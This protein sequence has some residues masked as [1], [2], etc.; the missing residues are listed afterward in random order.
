MLM[1]KPPQITMVWRAAAMEDSKACWVG[2]AS[3]M[4]PSVHGLIISFND[5]SQHTMRGCL[6]MS[7]GPVRF[8]TSPASSRPRAS[9]LRTPWHRL[10]VES[11]LFQHLGSTMADNNRIEYNWI[12][13]A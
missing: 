12:K 7:T 13:D 5:P 9:S 6:T 8:F 4:P 11:G 1:T 10:R 2:K 3:R